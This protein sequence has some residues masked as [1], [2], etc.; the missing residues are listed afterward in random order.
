[1]TTRREA[2]SEWS[3]CRGKVS[4]GLDFADAAGRAVV[5]TG[6]P[7]APRNNAK[8]RFLAL[9]SVI[10]RIFHLQVKLRRQRRSPLLPMP[11]VA[12]RCHHRHPLHAP[13]QGE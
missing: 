12:R 5:I 9:V 1:M 2:D 3:T 4:E 11:Q 6:I 7:Y 10:V 8:A 13:Q